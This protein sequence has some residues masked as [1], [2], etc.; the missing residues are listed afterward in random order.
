MMRGF[1]KVDFSFKVCVLDLFKHPN[2][3]ISRN[4]KILPGRTKGFNW[5]F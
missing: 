1:S 3:W 4:Q 2:L 5:M